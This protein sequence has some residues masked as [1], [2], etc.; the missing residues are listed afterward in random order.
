M[1]DDEVIQMD[2]GPRVTKMYRL[3][4]EYLAAS[5]GIPMSKVY[6]RALEAW[7][8]DYEWAKK[9]LEDFYG[10]RAGDLNKA[11]SEMKE[12]GIRQRRA[13]KAER[14]KRVRAA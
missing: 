13:A 5:N 10:L 2:G 14:E 7:M 1:R 3:L 11:M 8:A 6:Q 12:S 4:V 9:D